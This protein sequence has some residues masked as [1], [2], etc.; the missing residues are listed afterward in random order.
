[1]GHASRYDNLLYLKASRTRVFQSGP[2]TGGGTTI[3]GACDII[4]SGS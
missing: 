4:T 1:V 2:K 3:G